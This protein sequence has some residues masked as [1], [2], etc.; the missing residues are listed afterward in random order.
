MSEAAR[1]TGDLADAIARADAKHRAVSVELVMLGV[2]IVILALY[3]RE[4][5]SAHR[6]ERAEF[7]FVVDTLQSELAT[8]RRRYEVDSD[9]EAE[10]KTD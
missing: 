7:G 3:V 4:L 10:E 9:G 5:R 6:A 8:A 2:A 1:H